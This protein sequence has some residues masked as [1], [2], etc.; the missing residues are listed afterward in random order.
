[1]ANQLCISMKQKGIKPSTHHIYIIRIYNISLIYVKSYWENTHAIAKV[2]NI[3]I[4][5]MKIY[6]SQVFVFWKSMLLLNFS[7]Q[8][9][10]TGKVT[11]ILGEVWWLVLHFPTQVSENSRFCCPIKPKQQTVIVMK[12]PF[13]GGKIWDISV[14]TLISQWQRSFQMLVLIYIM[15]CC[16]CAK[17]FEARLVGTK[18]GRRNISCG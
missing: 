18:S 14:L 6:S 15:G 1:M 16:L 12:H 2:W 3:S 17:C 11:N 7:E 4:H 13:Y 5:T 10:F 8:S 9:G